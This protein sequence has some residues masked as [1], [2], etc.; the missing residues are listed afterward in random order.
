MEILRL[1]LRMTGWGGSGWHFVER[2]GGF[3]AAISLVH[4]CC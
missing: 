3:R 2:N 4:M 1:R